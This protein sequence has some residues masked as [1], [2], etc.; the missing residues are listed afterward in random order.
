MSVVQQ[1]CYNRANSHVVGL[2]AGANEGAGVLTNA[3]SVA[4]SETPTSNLTVHLLS[5]DPA[6]LVVADTVT[7]AAG[8]TGAV[9]DVTIVD[10]AE[11]DL[12]RSRI[13]PGGC[14]QPRRS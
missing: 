1:L 4:I 5:S 3:G 8:A 9:F 11:L 10:D 6:C 14:S 12:T 13:H 7:I 2:P